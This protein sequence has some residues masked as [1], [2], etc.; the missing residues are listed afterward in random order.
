MQIRPPI[1]IT[2]SPGIV[3]RLVSFDRNVTTLIVLL[4]WVPFS[5]TF[6]RYT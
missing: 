4:F 5:L 1:I 3:Y 2:R 6:D